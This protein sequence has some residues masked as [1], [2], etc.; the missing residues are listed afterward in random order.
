[1]KLTRSTGNRTH[2]TGTGRD[3]T[4]VARIKTTTAH[5]D[6]IR[7]SSEL[8]I[9]NPKDKIQDA[10][11]NLVTDGGDVDTRSG[12][13]GIK[14][15]NKL[16]FFIVD[17]SCGQNTQITEGVPVRAKRGQKRLH[18]SVRDRKNQMLA[19]API[20]IPLIS[21]V[22]RTTITFRITGKRNQCEPNQSYQRKNATPRTKTNSHHV[23]HPMNKTTNTKQ[24]KQRCGKPNIPIVT[25]I[26]IR[27]RIGGNHPNRWQLPTAFIGRITHRITSKK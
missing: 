12:Q 25:S 15:T 22:S 26:K 24:H 8:L 23:T 19:T 21:I 5:D 16:I 7:G 18:F 27:L 6:L 17:G 11:P 1:M 9:A 10:H 13:G 4:L 20:M 14:T 3:C 2:K